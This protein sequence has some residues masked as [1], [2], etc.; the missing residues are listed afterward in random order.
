MNALKSD[1]NPPA[2]FGSK[3]NFLAFEEKCIKKSRLIDSQIMEVIKRTSLAVPE[4]YGIR[5]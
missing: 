2:G 4:V 5:C 1:G 3:L